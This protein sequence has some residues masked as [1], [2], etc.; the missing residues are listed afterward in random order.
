MEE[1]SLK[2]IVENKTKRREK[3]ADVL[4]LREPYAINFNISNIC[5]FKCFYCAHG[6]SQDSR[7]KRIPEVM[8]FETLKNCIDHLKQENIHLKN[9]NL[10]GLGEPL[11]NKEFCRMVKYIKEQDVTE[12]VETI[13]NA[14]VLTKEYC[15][16]II[17]S[18]LDKI[19][20]SLQGLS[21][22]DYYHI[23]GVMLDYDE[24]YKNIQYLYENK[25]N[26]FIY[27]KIM[28]VMV[29]SEEQRKK[30][31]D[32]FKNIA[33]EVYIENLIPLTDYLDYSKGG[34]DFSETLYGEKVK[35]ITVCTQPFYSCTIDYDG[36]VFPCC[37]TPS[38]EKLEKASE[39][40]MDKI[41]NGLKYNLFLVTLLSGEAYQNNFAC[42]SC[43][44]Y[45]YMLLE[46]DSLE[47]KKEMLLE[48]YSEKVK[49]ERSEKG[50]YE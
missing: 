25:K 34:S 20:I 5:N 7:C 13:T 9:I 8:K 21:S 40:G 29:K 46:T 24:F 4:P 45:K 19:R 32:L 35:E 42:K 15:D 41:W 44:R 36:T 38:P 49:K 12:C 31:F 23:S 6:K 14:S 1:R 50:I 3:L 39:V 11:L 26:L 22:E 47:E 28:D 2:N 37:M 27:I 10:C 33:D 17:S 30:F 16:N 48:R 18:Q 43:N